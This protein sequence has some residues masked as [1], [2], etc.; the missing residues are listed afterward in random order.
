MNPAPAA[1]PTGVPSASEENP[2]EAM[3]RRFD[4]AAKRLGLDPA[5]Y[6]LLRMSDRELTVAIPIVMDDGSIRV[7][8]GY[9]VQHSIS[10]GP[11]KGGIRFSPDVT[12]EEVRA[13][14]AW[15]TW[16]CAVVGIPFGGAKGG[17][18]CDPRK[19]S[20]GEVERIARRYTASILD[21]LGPERDVPAPDMGTD[22]QVM[23][24]VMDTYSMHVRH[25][26]TAAVT[27]KPIA[28]GGSKGRRESTGRGVTLMAREAL[29]VLGM[30]RERCRVAIQGAGN[31]GSVA[32]GLFH[33]QGYRVVAMSDLTGGIADPDGLDVPSV[34]A[35]LQ[36]HRTL[37][38][39]G[40]GDRIDNAALLESDCEILVPAATENQI[41]SRNAERV[42]ARVLLEGANG[43]TT[44][45]ADAVLERRGAFVVPDILA[46]AGGVTVSYFEWVQDRMGYFWEESV[47]N[48]RMERILVSSFHDVRASAE[49]H[50]VS[51]RVGAYMLAIDR[52]AETT[53]LRG[54]YA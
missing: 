1:S 19:L 16:K 17:V 31:V 28:L 36:R 37:E 14:A 42:R 21:I 30:E 9:R 32:A 53:R 22:E 39:Y 5:L 15:M 47:V 38:G 7:F 26:E 10:R 48:E 40:G 51:M 46:N 2:Y 25:T 3:L 24:W 13:L 6:E 44:A 41:T 4:A 11:C 35:H 34:L 49:K 45:E 29:K 33:E 8:T 52:V 43:P 54:L 20:R 23:A 18:R 12:I 27:G 50:G